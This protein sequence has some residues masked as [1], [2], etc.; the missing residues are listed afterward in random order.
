MAGAIAYFN[1]KKYVESLV[2]VEGLR[3]G[4]IEKVL[5]VSNTAIGDTLMSTPAIRA[6]KKS[7]PHVGVGL[8]YHARNEQLIRHNPYID[9]RH[10]YRSKFHGMRSLIEDIKA[11]DYDLAA[12]LHGNDPESLPMLYLAGI[13]T[14]IGTAESK[15][16]FLTSDPLSTADKRLHTIEKRMNF[17]RRFGAASD[18]FYMDFFIPEDQK[19]RSRKIIAER[20]GDSPGPIVAFHPAGSDPYK[21]WPADRFVEVAERLWRS[22]GAKIIVMCGAKESEVG[23]AIAGKTAGPSFCT[24]GKYNLLE[25]G[26]MLGQCALMITTDSGPM[27][28]SFALNVPTLALSADHPARIGPYGIDDAVMLYHK[29]GVCLESVCLKKRCPANTCMQAISTDQVFTVISNQFAKHL[30]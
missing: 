29:D 22:Y 21:W 4:G 17:V 3:P 25:V 18:G 20:F 11:Q 19:A 14:I 6:V 15:F 27:H 30:S 16:R 1:R 28:M 7:F 23:E 10:E 24:G 9:I 26:G 5:L 8:V 12:I 2:P 13:R